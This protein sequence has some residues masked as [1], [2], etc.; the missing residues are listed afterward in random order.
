MRECPSCGSVL[1]S[2][3]RSC[4]CGW[5]VTPAVAPTATAKGA[6]ERPLC[7]YPG[8]RYPAMVSAR[9][10]AKWYCR[11]HF[12][13]DD[14]VECATIVERSLTWDPAAEELARKQREQARALESLSKFGLARRVGE[15]YEAWI[16]RQRE[17][18]R[19]G[20]QVLNRRMKA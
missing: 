19:R 2:M 7:S 11:W 6:A 5:Q 10:G 4:E 9:A 15:P 18:C 17:F 13:R 20:L 16:A 1:A 3:A 12:E 14:P 8:C